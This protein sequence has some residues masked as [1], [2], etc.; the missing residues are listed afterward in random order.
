MILITNCSDLN[1]IEELKDLIKKELKDAKIISD[2]T[3]SNEERIKKFID[4]LLRYNAIHLVSTN[5][6]KEKI[7]SAVSDYMIKNSKTFRIEEW[8]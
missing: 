1:S 6:D 7:L 4:K 2:I 3:E 8:S 5:E